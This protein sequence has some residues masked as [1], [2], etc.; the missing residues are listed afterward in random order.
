MTNKRKIFFALLPS[1]NNQK[2]I[3]NLQRKF[4]SDAGKWIVS[5]NIH[6]TL[7][8]IGFVD[9]KALECIVAVAK[10]VR[11]KNINLT[12]DVIC[13]F[14]KAKILWLGTDEKHIH[15]RALHKQ[16]VEKLVSCDVNINQQAFRPH[17]T[18]ARKI[19]KEIRAPE[20]EA[21]EWFSDSFYL[22]ESI[23]IPEGVIYKIL[24]KYQLR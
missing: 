17:V 19:Q 14:N 4:H 6:M 8:F 2:Q 21:I 12:L 10:D 15:L 9:E 18:L 13:Q 5:Q 20:F 23:Q 16:L 22:M 1:E 24:N 7:C 3:N 11:S